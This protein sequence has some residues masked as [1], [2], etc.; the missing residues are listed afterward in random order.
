MSAVIFS[1]LVGSAD[2][3]SQPLT[4]ARIGYQNF[5]TS[6]NITPSSQLANFPAA[7]VANPATYDKWQPVSLPATLTIDAG[8]AVDVDYVGIAA[9]TI[10][11]KSCI[12]SISYSFDN[13]SYTTIGETSPGDDSSIMMLFTKTRARYWRLTISGSAVPVVGVLYIGKTLEM[14]RPIYGGHSPIN[15]SRITAVRPNVSESGQWLGSSIERVGLKTSFEWR[16]LEAQWYR[17]NFDKF[18]RT[19]PQARPFFIAWRPSKFPKEVGYC[20]ATG[21]I[22]PQNM[23]IR[24]YMS[25]SMSVEGYLGG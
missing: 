18:V 9:H 8:N 24:D 3:A 22:Q 11:S 14:Q 17:D 19:Y 13:S 2:N 7:A 20:W 25:V 6:T 5:A 21:D 12:A 15:L 23:G 10:G 4:H 1:G 16:H